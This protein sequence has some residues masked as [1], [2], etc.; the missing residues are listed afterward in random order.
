MCIRDRINR[1]EYSEVFRDKGID[2]VISPK[3]LTANDIVRYVRAMH[4]TTGGSV[5]T[6]HRIVDNKVE[7]LE[8]RVT[9]TTR[10]L[11]ETL[12]QITLKPNILLACINRYGKIIIPKGE[13]TIE[14]NDTVIVVTTADQTIYDLNDIFDDK[15]EASDYEY[16]INDQYI[17]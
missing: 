15:I 2:C 9:E 8:F 16:T 14:L 12:L 1:T 6:L 4:N 17:V 5:L 7:A 11:G 13:D 10:H 3:L